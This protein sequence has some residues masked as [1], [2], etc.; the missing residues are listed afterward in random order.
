MRTNSHEDAPALTFNDGL[1][2]VHTKNPDSRSVSAF[3]F[4]FSPAFGRIIQF[5]QLVRYKHITELS[6][7]GHKFGDIRMLSNLVLLKK[8]NL[9]WN[10]ITDIRPLTSLVSLEV[11]NLSHNRVAKIPVAFENLMD[12]HTL[13]LSFNRIISQNEVTHLKENKALRTV[14]LEGNTFMN[15][16]DATHFVVFTLPQITTLNRKKVNRDS[17]VQS[18]QKFSVARALD[19]SS[20]QGQ[21]RQEE[22]RGDGSDFVESGS[23]FQIYLGEVQNRRIQSLQQIEKTQ[24]ENEDLKRQLNEMKIGM[25]FAKTV[26]ERKP[27]L[28]DEEAAYKIKKL[29]KKLFEA[30]KQDE[31]LNESLA[32]EK[33]VNMKQKQLYSRLKE[34]YEAERRSKEP[35][36]IHPR[37]PTPPIKKSAEIRLEMVRDENKRL[38]AKVRQLEADAECH[39]SE[40]ESQRK[41][42]KELKAAQSQME[43]VSN[44]NKL[45]AESQLEK[46]LNK[47]KESFE[48][49]KRRYEGELESLKVL[50]RE[51]ES[52]ISQQNEQI[53]ELRKDIEDSRSIQLELTRSLEKITQEDNQIK[54]EQSTKIKDLEIVLR[55]RGD[56]IQGLRSELSKKEFTLEEMKGK[57]YTLETT[58]E[59]YQS[60]IDEMMLDKSSNANSSLLV[61]T[62]EGQLTKTKA[63]MESLSQEKQSVEHEYQKLQK[64]HQAQAKQFSELKKQVKVLSEKLRDSHAMNEVLTKENNKSKELVQ[65][66]SDAISVKERQIAQLKSEREGLIAR[67][68]SEIRARDTRIEGLEKNLESVSFSAKPPLGNSV[69]DV[70]L[71][72]S[73]KLELDHSLL[74][75]RLQDSELSVDKVQRQ[76]LNY[77]K[78]VRA[79]RV[80]ISNQEET[81]EGMRSALVSAQETI[82]ELK[83]EIENKKELVVDQVRVNQELTAR[84]S[85]QEAEVQQIVAHLNRKIASLK[86]KLTEKASR[87]ASSSATAD[88]VRVSNVETERMLVQLKRQLAKKDTIIHDLRKSV[89]HSTATCVGK[90]EAIEKQLSDARAQLFATRELHS[91][92]LLEM[93]NLAVMMSVKC[94]APIAT[95]D[96]DS[97]Q[98]FQQLVGEIQTECS[99]LKKKLKASEAKYDEERSQY[100]SSVAKLVDAI[101]KKDD[102]ITSLREQ[103]KSLSER[104]RDQDAHINQLKA[105]E[106]EQ[107][108]EEALAKE[109]T[110]LSMKLSQ[111]EHSSDSLVDDYRQQTSQQLKELEETK[112]EYQKTIS[113]LT[114]KKRELKKDN[115]RMST[116]I[117]QLSQTVR[118]KSAELDR[119][120]TK[121]QMY[122][123][124]RSDVVSSIEAIEQRSQV[125]ELSLKR[126]LTET[127]SL[128]Q[129]A[130]E[131]EEVFL[132]QIE[133]ANTSNTELTAKVKELKKKLAAS[134][135]DANELQLKMKETKEMNAT[136]MAEREEELTRC[137]ETIE[138]L[139]EQLLAARDEFHANQNSLVTEK[140]EV[141]FELMRSQ[142]TIDKMSKKLVKL[143]KR[144]DEE[145]DVGNQSHTANIDLKK[146]NKRLKE[147]LQQAQSQVQHITDTNAMTEHVFKTLS[148]KY[149]ALQNQYNEL[150][151][152]L[153]AEALGEQRLQLS[154]RAD[155]AERSNE[156]LT[157]EVEKLKGKLD[158][159]QLRLTEQKSQIGQLQD[160]LAVLKEQ[161]RKVDTDLTQYMDKLNESQKTIQ[162]LQ[163]QFRES[164]Q[165][166]RDLSS[167]IS[168]TKETMVDRREYEVLLQRFER[169]RSKRQELKSELARQQEQGAQ[170]NN[171]I[172]QR[173]AE[174]QK[175]NEKIEKMEQQMSQEQ[176][177]FK[178]QVNDLK[179]KISATRNQNEEFQ[180]QIDE[181]TGRVESL[182]DTVRKREEAIV[183]MK[184]GHTAEMQAMQQKIEEL[185][186]ESNEKDAQ[187]SEREHEKKDIEEKWAETSTDLNSK[188]QLYDEKLA[189]LAKKKEKMQA[190]HD[191]IVRELAQA[192]RQIRALQEEKEHFDEFMAEKEMH[193]QQLAGRLEGSVKRSVYD[194][195]L[196]KYNEAKHLKMF[197][198]QKMHSSTFE[199]ERQK[200][201]MEKMFKEREESL[202]DDIRDLRRQIDRQKNANA[203]LVG[204]VQTLNRRLRAYV[205]P[206]SEMVSREDL[207]I[208]EETHEQT[209]KELK[210]MTDKYEVAQ[211]HNEDLKK[212]LSQKVKELIVSTEKEKLQAE[213]LSQVQDALDTKTNLVHKITEIA[214]TLQ[215]TLRSR[216]CTVAKCCS[217]LNPLFSLLEMSEVTMRSLAEILSRQSET[218]FDL[219]PDGHHDN[220]M[221]MLM[222]CKSDLTSIPIKYD[223]NLLQSN[224]Y[225]LEAQIKTI[226]EMIIQAKS[227][228]HDQLA[229]MREMSSMISSQ[230][231]ALLKVNP[232]DASP[233]VQLPPLDL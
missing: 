177:H 46:Q 210:L 192:R 111:L 204:E 77:Q 55:Q 136:I 233:R 161:K 96:N 163:N 24:T 72:E 139:R 118:S 76:L 180:V 70:G 228:I 165:V 110:D 68:S 151:K 149:T 148:L 44:E 23:A 222:K 56:V 212:E 218:V 187:I 176:E 9:S 209:A 117:E 73:T 104:I 162:I 179:D 50:C 57:Q 17:R 231:A 129:A 85:E 102:Q 8:L 51:K 202:S 156:K 229:H 131:R 29:K 14:D 221:R 159:S 78:E 49:E 39:V 193:I 147:A 214:N 138:G 203:K 81:I 128:L 28:G 206:N 171:T 90:E 170:D 64:L 25:A 59:S 32:F 108:I 80:K 175:L 93:E 60:R 126:E 185:T 107:L 227:Y 105:R 19:A 6:L 26:T 33:A 87:E 86:E 183:Q 168:E 75:M 13:N 157:R 184:Q 116:E 97:F 54:S 69:M 101:R 84:Y 190:K 146:E 53:A 160:E 38:L 109:K 92:I 27:E 48:Q 164:T 79:Q 216:D 58:L 213:Q 121:L 217:N 88:A 135:I 201:T 113:K 219:R 106:Q 178:D 45:E 120:S 42:I 52:E 144:L 167:Q 10:S 16:D 11:L 67:M 3:T 182:K 205:N 15:D 100:A 199:F 225:N 232:G 2:R 99:D 134:R 140:Q 230:H 158:A 152:S 197:S 211:T 132:S 191:E 119:L 141:E 91:R 62:Y 142:D 82:E 41:Q 40:I 114:D 83:E 145:V 71:D 143:S 220:M 30:R 207:R 133:A 223:E 37:T 194:E 224:T 89:E 115:E 198:E 95:L 215:G 154:N 66:A 173:E 188:M 36:G 65:A 12:L 181:L 112:T 94:E 123:T 18:T 20:F 4:N 22:A 195:L 35:V 226:G 153:S 174:I 125:R 127:E 137:V 166:S 1:I 122:E 130:K 208:L 21:E 34:R 200:E 7:V 150:E 5:E 186:A 47:Q 124:Y 74:S 63:E 103:V 43:A 98:A 155:Q 189:G 31:K 196:D 169:G 172:E 61:D